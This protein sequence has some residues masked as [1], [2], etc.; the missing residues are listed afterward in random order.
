MCL[1]FVIFAKRIMARIAGVS[2]DKTSRGDIKKVTFDLSKLD[3]ES[4][5]IIEDAIDKIIASERRNDETVPWEQVKKELDR[6][7]GIKRKK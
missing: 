6:K 4:V 1:L 2:F 5:E 7:H 3:D